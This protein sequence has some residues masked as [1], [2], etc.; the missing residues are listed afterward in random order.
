VSPRR[1]IPRSEAW[2]ERQAGIASQ[3]HAGYR[4]KSAMSTHHPTIDA[5]RSLFL[6][7]ESCGSRSMMSGT[8]DYIKVLVVLNS[9]NTSPL[10]GWL[11]QKS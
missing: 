6:R 10:R 5:I 4:A 9:I 8:W 3:F 11:R 2:D 1:C 7:R